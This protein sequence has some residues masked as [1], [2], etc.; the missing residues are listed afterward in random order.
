MRINNS[1]YEISG[2]HWD[3]NECRGDDTILLIQSA[4]IKNNSSRMKTLTLITL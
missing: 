2:N 1:G 4:A 3:N